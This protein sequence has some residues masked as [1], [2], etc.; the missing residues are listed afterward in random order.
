MG[1]LPVFVSD[2][3]WSV[4]LPFQCLVPWRR[5]AFSVAEEV[6]VS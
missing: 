3:L 4:G 6:R 1:T 2:E 5:F